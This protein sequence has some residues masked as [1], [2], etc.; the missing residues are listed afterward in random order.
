[1][2]EASPF[3]LNGKVAIVTG[4][5]TGIGHGIALAL[6]AA[7]A[8]VV[9]AARRPEPVDQA[10]ADVRAL[11]RRALGVPTDVSRADQVERLVRSARDE[12][13]RIDTLVN[14]AGGTFGPTFKRNLLLETSEHDFQECFSVNVT[15]AFLCA[16]AVVPLMT[17]QGGG[18]IINVSSVGGHEGGT[19]MVGFS[20]YG[21]AKAALIHLTRGMAAEWGPQVRVNC[22]A[23]GTIDTPRVTASRTQSEQEALV[24]GIAMARQGLPED[25]AGAAVFLASDAASWITG[26]CLDIHGGVKRDYRT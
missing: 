20:V 7:G 26:S 9:I 22:L 4:G 25:V 2:A 15:S 12:F 5:S 13:G 3:R 21:A 8:D 23:P 14:N 16:T 18:S 6:A 19:P 1:M 11:G 24:R 10:C 17:E